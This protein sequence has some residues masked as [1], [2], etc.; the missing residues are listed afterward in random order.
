VTEP[1]L[2]S[3]FV[4]G[5]LVF[6][7]QICEKRSYLL[8]CHIYE[9]PIRPGHKPLP[10]FGIKDTEEPGQEAKELSIREALALLEKKKYT[11]PK[12]T[13][14]QMI[15]E[16][17]QNS[18]TSVCASKGPAAATVFVTLSTASSLIDHISYH[19]FSFRRDHE[20][21]IHQ[22][23]IDKRSLTCIVA[24]APTLGCN[25]LDE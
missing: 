16:F 25:T 4:E 2:R 14:L 20:T 15:G 10:N 8:H 17:N 9:N 7:A 1:L 22:L 5:L 24:S 18:D 19:S 23:R 21:M 11:Y 13:L 3:G 6:H 12:T